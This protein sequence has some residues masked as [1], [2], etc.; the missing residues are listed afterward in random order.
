MG[1]AQAVV[2]VTNGAAFV[3]N[4]IILISQGGNYLYAR[5]DA[6][7]ATSLTFTPMDIAGD[8]A[9]GTQFT[10][11]ALIG[12]VGAQGPKG[13]KGD[14]GPSPFTTLTGAYTAGPSAVTL[15][16]ADSTAF[17]VNSNVMLSQGL[18]YFY[19][20][21]TGKPS[22]TQLAVTP[23]HVP[24]DANDGTLFTV[25]T[26]IGVAGGQGPTGSQG[27][28]GPVFAKGYPLTGG[29][30]TLGTP[31]N[32]GPMS[33]TEGTGLVVSGHYHF[34]RDGNIYSGPGW[35]AEMSIRVQISVD[36]SD[37]TYDRTH[38]VPVGL[39]VSAD[40]PFSVLF[41]YSAA[42]LGTEMNRFV[43]VTITPSQGGSAWGNITVLEAR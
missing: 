6:A 26:Q 21:V 9:N 36:G 41:P 4:S 24:G 12:V 8:A 23:V 35:L 11:G 39:V 1:T 16:V 27:P 30:G 14:T 32:T 13:D 29:G 31:A 2:G 38:R 28:A 19:A 22:A 10:V 43:H 33:S 20:R 42:T 25:G 7:T 40:I 15:S 3:P 34:E 5:L 17:V 37:V 18:N